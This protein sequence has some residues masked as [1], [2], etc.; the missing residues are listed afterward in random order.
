MNCFLFFACLFNY[1][2]V[3][4]DYLR[5]S[6]ENFNHDDRILQSNWHYG[7]LY[8]VNAE[9]RKYGLHDL[10]LNKKLIYVA[11]IHSY[12]QASR[13]ILSHQG[14]DGSSVY[15]RINKVGFN[16][17]FAAENVASGQNSIQS[18]FNSWMKS[19]SHRGNILSPQAKFFGVGYAPSSYNKPFWTQV[20]AYGP[21][22]HCN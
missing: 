14:S 7:M 3:R 12:D 17:F 4:G 16:W 20:F 22:E 2:V 19:D 8:L 9:R 21:A 5:G 10:C 15:S 11:Q 13:N 1:L 6:E 18:V